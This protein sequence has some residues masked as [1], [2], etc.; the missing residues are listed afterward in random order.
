MLY[1]SICYEL[2]SFAEICPTVATVDRFIWPRWNLPED[3]HSRETEAPK[4][5]VT[6]DPRFTSH[7]SGSLL[8]IVSW[9]P[10]KALPNNSEDRGHFFSP[11]GSLFKV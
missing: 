4:F 11:L 1:S 10:G 6:H 8:W 3:M 7:I 2:D 5:E 9:K